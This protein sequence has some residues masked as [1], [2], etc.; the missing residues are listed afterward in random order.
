MKIYKK[1]GRIGK[2]KKKIQTINQTSILPS[3]NNNN[4]SILVKIYE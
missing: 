4:F 1:E 3:N 2:K